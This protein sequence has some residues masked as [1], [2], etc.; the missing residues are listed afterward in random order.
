MANTTRPIGLAFKRKLVTT[1]IPL[2][3][4]VLALAITIAVLYTP[5]ATAIPVTIGA[6]QFQLSM[7]LLAK[8]IANA[9]ASVNI[10]QA[11][12]N[13]GF[14]FSNILPNNSLTLTIYGLALLYI[15]SNLSA[16]LKI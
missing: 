13:A 15:S 7:I 5:K 1:I 14:N 4:K 2:K 10:F 12:V 16:N 8:S 9:P 11:S 6:I 3:S